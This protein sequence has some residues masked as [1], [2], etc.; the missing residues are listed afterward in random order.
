MKKT[1]YQKESLE[2]LVDKMGGLETME[3]NPKASILPTNSRFNS[4][5]FLTLLHRKTSYK[6][7]MKSMERLSSK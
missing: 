3:S 4:L 6:E 2:Q 5:L 1:I 7:L